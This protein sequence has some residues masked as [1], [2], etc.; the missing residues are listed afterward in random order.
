MKLQMPAVRTDRDVA[1]QLRG[2]AGHDG[3]GSFPL[4]RGGAEGRGILFPCAVKDLLDLKPVH[5]ASLPTCQK[6]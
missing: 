4:D 5:D 2:L 3:G 1:A 6:G